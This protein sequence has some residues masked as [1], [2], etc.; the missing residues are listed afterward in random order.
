MD[1]I[2]RMAEPRDVGALA[3]LRA[4]LW[5]EGTADEHAAELHDMLRV[6]ANYISVAESDGALI[7]FV[8]A[9]LR[10]H[11]DGCET[12]PVG[13]LEGWF[14]A[15][16]WRGRGVGRALV[17][18]FE[19]WAAAQ[20]CRELAS[21]TWLDNVGSQHAHAKLGFEEVDRVVTYRKS[22]DPDITIGPHARP[23]AR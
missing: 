20:G 9:R 17:Q 1:V 22:L 6:P 23:P 13:Y 21:D 14:V 5:P 8:E 3:A 11:A 12:S 18:R 10:S 2:V 7:G 4:T 19:E 15:D 16:H